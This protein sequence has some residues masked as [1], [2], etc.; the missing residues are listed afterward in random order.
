MM[1]N[2]LWLTKFLVAPFFI[3]SILLVPGCAAVPAVYADPGSKIAVE[4]GKEFVIDLESNPT[5]GYS[6]QETH[7]EMIVRLTGKTYEQSGTGTPVVGGG[8]VETFRFQALKSGT[9]EIEFFYKRA[10]EAE[11]IKETKFYVIVK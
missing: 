10:W 7:D 1:V 2:R 4:T 3:G 5:T 11:P 9:T 6:W 8:G